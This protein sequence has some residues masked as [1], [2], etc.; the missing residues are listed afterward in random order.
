MSTAQPPHFPKFDFFGELPQMHESIFR[1]N[2]GTYITGEV[3][4][5]FSLAATCVEEDG[6]RRASMMAWKSQ[7]SERHCRITTVKA[8]PT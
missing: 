8:T 7:V 3:L 2:L 6:H 1:L 4:D 5:D